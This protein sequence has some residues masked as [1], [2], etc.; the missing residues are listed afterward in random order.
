MQ[1]HNTGERHYIGHAQ[2]QK[3]PLICGDVNT[4]EVMAC[5][6]QSENSMENSELK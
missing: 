3:Q 6:Q 4:V 2:K 5:S 1:N